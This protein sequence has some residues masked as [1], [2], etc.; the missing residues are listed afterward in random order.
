MESQAQLSRTHARHVEQIVDELLLRQC[1]TID[2]FD[3]FGPILVRQ[4][5]AAEHARPQANGIQRR[6]QLVAH[7]GDEF[8]F[9]T[10]GAFHRRTDR[11]RVAQRL[12][13]LI[14]RLPA[15]G[16]VAHDLGKPLQYAIRVGEAGQN[17][18]G[19]ESRAVFAY[20][21]PLIGRPVV[22]QCALHFLLHRARLAILRREYDGD[23]AM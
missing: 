1:R 23:G 5:P 12:L 3:A 8:I 6:S 10:V 17:A 7:R 4:P 2:D 9:C 22:L 11:L 16:I 18:A 15:F 14:S 21:L 13:Q 20:V 19:P